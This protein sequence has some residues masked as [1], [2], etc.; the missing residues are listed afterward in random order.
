[1]AQA[2]RTMVIMGNVSC[3]VVRRPLPLFHPSQARLGWASLLWHLEGHVTGHEIE[4][5]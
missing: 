2:D 4:Q 5:Y 1:M 3:S